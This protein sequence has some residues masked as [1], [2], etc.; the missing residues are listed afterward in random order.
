MITAG[1]AIDDWKLPI[2][3]KHLNEAN[4]AFKINPGVS[5]GT[6]LLTV[7]CLSH[8]EL[9]KPVMAANKEAKMKGTS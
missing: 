3:E 5:P 1:I 7:K 8:R 9:E 6:L 2:F 4:I